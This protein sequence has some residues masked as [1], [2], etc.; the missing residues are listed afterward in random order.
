MK[1]FVY[2]SLIVW[3]VLSI[4]GFA[5]G[6]EEDVTAQEFP[7]VGMVWGG[8]DIQSR[9]DVVYIMYSEINRNG[10]ESVY[11]GWEFPTAN[12]SDG[13]GIAKNCAINLF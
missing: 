8:G 12:S 1:R 6:I 3:L 9:D 13:T 5:G 2:L 10:E 7:V 4:T 11:Y